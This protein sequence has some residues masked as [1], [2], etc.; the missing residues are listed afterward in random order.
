MATSLAGQYPQTAPTWHEGLQQDDRTINVLLTTFAGLGLP[1]TLSLP[2]NASTTVHDL[3]NTIYDRLPEVHH[4]LIITTTSNKQLLFSTNDAIATL[5][6]STSDTFLPLRLSARLCGG[7]GGFGSQLRAAGGRMS[8]R[9]NRQNQNTNGSNRTLEGRRVRVVAAA[10]QL[11]EHMAKEKEVE[12][13]ARQERKQK[14]EDTIDAADRKMETI[15]SGKSGVN[16]GRLDAEYVESKELAEEKTR[17]A[18]M[19]AMKLSSAALERTGSES[20]MEV[21]E[22]ASDDGEAEDA[23]SGSSEDAAPLNPSRSGPAFFGWDDED[24]EDSEED[25]EDTKRQPVHEGKGK[26]KAG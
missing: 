21:D 18:I 15:K 5:L 11:A 12:E 16:Q 25:G 10:K 19:N 2:I 7:K 20:S 17:E 13:Q 3:L 1:R 23:T 14:L 22:T 4:A 24:D 8:S 6:P 26:A 9:K